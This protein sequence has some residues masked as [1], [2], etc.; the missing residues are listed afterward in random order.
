MGPQDHSQI[1]Q[2]TKRTHRTEHIVVL[3]DLLQQK[4]AKANQ[5]RVKAHGAKSRGSQMQASKSPLPMELHRMCL[6]LPALNCENMCKML[7]TRRSC[8]KL[9]T[10]CFY[11]GLVTQAACTQHIPKFQTLRRKAGV[12]HKPYIFAQFTQSVPH[13]LF[14]K[15]WKYSPNPTSQMPAKG[16]SYKQDFLRITG[17]S[18]LLY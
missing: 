7:F 10:Q 14:R 17:I 5:Q 4:D 1:Q 12:Q 13:L 11:W 6:I 16:Q 8:Q 3:L 2:F 9:S 18:G 15:W